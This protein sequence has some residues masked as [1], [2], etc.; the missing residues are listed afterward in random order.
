M[1]QYYQRVVEPKR[2]GLSVFVPDL[3][4]RE[5][6]DGSRQY[7]AIVSAPHPYAP[8]RM[9]LAGVV[10]SGR[11]RPDLLENMDAI[12]TANG[13]MSHATNA[14]AAIL[15]KKLG[16][17]ILGGSDAHLP[18]FIGHALTLA[19][20]DVPLLDAIRQGRTRTQGGGQNQL[21]SAAVFFLGQGKIMLQPNGWQIFRKNLAVYNNKALRDGT[22]KEA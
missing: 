21:I 18:G 10:D 20:A 14:Q 16:K 8:G 12:E 19:P 5:I 6:V 11:I 22:I 9:G 13:M 1:V 17:P 4:E 15:A 7:E 3:T 2:Q